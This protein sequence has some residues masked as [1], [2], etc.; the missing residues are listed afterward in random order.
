MVKHNK[1]EV[2]DNNKKMEEVV[3]KQA[4]TRYQIFY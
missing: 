1:K 3:G 2:N 4:P